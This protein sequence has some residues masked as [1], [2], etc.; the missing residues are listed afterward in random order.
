[1]SCHE[2][3]THRMDFEKLSQ[4]GLFLQSFDRRGQPKGTASKPGKPNKL[5]LPPPKFNIA[6]EKFPSQ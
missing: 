6:P 5:L 4:L 2:L 1:M 3:F